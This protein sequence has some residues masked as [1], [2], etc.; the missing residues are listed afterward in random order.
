MRA[1]GGDH[2]S[3]AQCLYADVKGA[4]GMGVDVLRGGVKVGVKGWEAQIGGV[5]GMGDVVGLVWYGM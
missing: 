4:E 1:G 3:A 2:L 5:H